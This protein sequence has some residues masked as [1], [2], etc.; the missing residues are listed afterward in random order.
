MYTNGIPDKVFIPNRIPYKSGGN[1]NNQVA[2][3]IPQALPI[4]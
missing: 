1:K 3:T 2:A 4:V